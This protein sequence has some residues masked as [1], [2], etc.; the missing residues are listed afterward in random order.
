LAEPLFKSERKNI[1]EVLGR[2]VHEE[3]QELWYPQKSLTLKKTKKL[4]NHEN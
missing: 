3:F 1:L 2:M 4:Y